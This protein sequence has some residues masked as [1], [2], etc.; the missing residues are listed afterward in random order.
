[1]FVGGRRHA[2]PIYRVT[3]TIP[4]GVP[5]VSGPVRVP[6]RQISK[7]HWAAFGEVVTRSE[8]AAYGLIIDEPGE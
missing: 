7:G 8:L 2:K 4:E 3:V 6:L 1:M 5:G